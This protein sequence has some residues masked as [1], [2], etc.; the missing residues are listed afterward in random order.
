MPAT[1]LIPAKTHS[2]PTKSYNGD[3]VSSPL[4]PQ[5]QSED[6]SV[7][8]SEPIFGALELHT[9]Q[10]TKSYFISRFKKILKLLYEETDFDDN[11]KNNGFVIPVKQETLKELSD[12][13]SFVKQTDD[14]DVADHVSDKCYVT[15]KDGLAINKE[16][17]KIKR[18]LKPDN[19][20]EKARSLFTII[21]KYFKPTPFVSTEQYLGKIQS[22]KNSSKIIEIK[23]LTA[24]LDD[25]ILEASEHNLTFK[26]K[27]VKKNLLV[28]VTVQEDW[29]GHIHFKV[30]RGDTIPAKPN[31]KEVIQSIK[32]QIEEY[33]ND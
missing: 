25:D 3:S 11:V 31:E 28:T 2:T 29:G 13:S 20:N 1:D 4:M 33:L 30:D 16:C 14:N 18:E 15:T 19:C 9:L 10:G 5:E 8:Y 12:F 23:I 6:V 7:S 26:W 32:K 17:N 27:Y 22:V 21:E 24:N